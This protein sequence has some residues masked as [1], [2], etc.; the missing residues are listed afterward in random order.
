MFLKRLKKTL[1]TTYFI[2]SLAY[3]SLLGWM[4]CF[5]FLGAGEVLCLGWRKIVF[6]WWKSIDK[7]GK[8]C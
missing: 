7:N 4:V 3:L 6:G 8:V 2:D 5:I 1:H